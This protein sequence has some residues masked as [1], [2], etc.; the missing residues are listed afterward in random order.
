MF[1]DVIFSIIILEDRLSLMLLVLVRNDQASK[2]RLQISRYA[3]LSP[4]L[5]DQSFLKRKI[6][7]VLTGRK[8]ADKKY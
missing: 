6:K 1:I 8:Q 2:N 5:I 4:R 3:T 7:P